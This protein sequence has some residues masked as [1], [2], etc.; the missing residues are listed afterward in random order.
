[1]RNFVIY[2]ILFDISL[3]NMPFSCCVNP[4]E[5][6]T[7]CEFLFLSKHLFDNLKFSLKLCCFHKKLNEFIFSYR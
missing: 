3:S 5:E 6:R 7:W 1:M 2:E 4:I